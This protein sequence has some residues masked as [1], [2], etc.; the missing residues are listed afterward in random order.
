MGLPTDTDVPRM[1][2]LNWIIVSPG[3]TS[4]YFLEAEVV[5]TGKQLLA[6]VA[7]I[8]MSEL[9]LFVPSNSRFS[10][11]L[12]RIRKIE[13]CGGMSQTLQ[14][15]P[16]P[17]EMS[18]PPDRASASAQCWEYEQATVCLVL[19]LD[20]GLLLNVEI[21]RIRILPHGSDLRTHY[22]SQRVGLRASMRTEK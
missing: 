4:R 17:L 9:L 8:G 21:G 22:F 20:H 2:I 16:N 3:C 6:W 12:E 18:R 19:G 11:R 15:F 7:E 1:I 13:P 14:A 10:S 5:C